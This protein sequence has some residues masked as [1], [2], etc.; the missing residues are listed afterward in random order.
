MLLAALLIAATSPADCQA[1]AKLVDTPV[2]ISATPITARQLAAQAIQELPPPLPGIRG[3]SRIGELI[4]LGDG[5]EIRSADPRF[6]GIRV[7]HNSVAAH[8]CGYSVDGPSG[9]NA[10]DK[11]LAARKIRFEKKGGADIPSPGAMEAAAMGARPLLKGAT[12]GPTWPLWS[13][14]SKVFLAVMYPDGKPQESL[15]V[16]F[17]G[18]PYATPARVLA[19]LRMHV[20]GLSVMPALHAPGLFLYLHERTEDGALRHVVLKLEHETAEKLARQP[21]P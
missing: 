18:R 14:P 17:A 21:E 15:I 12:A 10:L 20:Q 6:Q 8:D 11:D 19:R 1:F 5:L 2:A 16:A 7:R 9:W 13:G 4:Y 3:G